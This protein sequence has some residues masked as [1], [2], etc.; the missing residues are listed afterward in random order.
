[1]KKIYILL[2]TLF[3]T[4]S[5]YGQNVFISEIH[6][7]TGVEVTGPIN[8]SLNGHSISVYNSFGTQLTSVS[9]TGSLTGGSGSLSAKNFTVTNLTIGG[10]FDWGRTIVLRNGSVFVDGI[11]Y[12]FVLS[13][14]TGIP[15]GSIAHVGSQPNSTNGNPPDSTQFTTNGGWQTGIPSSKGIVN[16]GQTLAVVKNNIEGFNMYPNPVSNGQLTITSNSWADKQVEIYSLS[17][18]QVY[19]K[20]VKHKEIIEIYNLNKGIYLV[21]IVE[22]GKIATRKLVVN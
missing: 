12:G 20:L 16:T 2:I 1:M 8:T 22:E 19:N 15:S 21:R 6:V 14:P 17:G 10:W 9:L 18:Q 3:I 4:I 5:S 11:S 7:V 13:N